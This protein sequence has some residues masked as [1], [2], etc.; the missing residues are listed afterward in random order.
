MYNIVLKIS[1]GKCAR[2]W[3]AL[4]KNQVFQS[5]NDTYKWIY[6]NI[7]LHIWLYYNYFTCSW[8]ITCLTLIDTKFSNQLSKF[9][10]KENQC[11]FFVRF[12]TMVHSYWRSNKKNQSISLKFTWCKFTNI[13]YLCKLDLEIFRV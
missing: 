12:S 6:T 3:I 4:N 5:E 7:K 11:I 8:E 1:Y 13:I 2:I 9:A 10:Q